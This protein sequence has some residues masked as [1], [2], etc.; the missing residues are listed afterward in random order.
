MSTFLPSRNLYNYASFVDFYR[1]Y[2]TRENFLHRIL[3]NLIKDR[4][5]LIE[6]VVYKTVV[7]P[8]LCKAPI[9]PIEEK[10]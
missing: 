7:I 6:E 8:I 5:S 4:K 3:L 10:A 9:C 2:L 1:L